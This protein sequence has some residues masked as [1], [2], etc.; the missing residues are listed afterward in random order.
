MLGAP[1]VVRGGSHVGW[2]GAADMIKQGCCTV[3]A[4]DYYYPAPLLA[5]FRLAADDVAPLPRAWSYVSGNAAR[6]AALDDR[7]RL[8][9]GLRADV[10]LV[11]GSDL[12][13]PSVVATMV[14]GRL[15]HLTEPGRLH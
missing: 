9:A 14:N 15:V 3:L 2:I 4:S 1:N 12:A 10:I 8:E 13:H 7:G 11:D 6:A 5:A